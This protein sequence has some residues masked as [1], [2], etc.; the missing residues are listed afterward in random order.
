[1]TA[2]LSNFQ[3]LRSSLISTFASPFHSSTSGCKNFRQKAISYITLERVICERL[4]LY[5]SYSGKCPHTRSDLLC[6]VLLFTSRSSSR[7][8][9]LSF[10]LSSTNPSCT[11]GSTRSSVRPLATH[12][13]ISSMAPSVIPEPPLI[14]LSVY[15]GLTFSRAPIAVFRNRVVLW[16]LG[17]SVGNPRSS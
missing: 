16:V 10:Y 12:Y 2:V 11:Y 9:L 17:G 1:M 13:I 3:P 5:I 7:C 8:S 15:T 6:S 4:D 14:W